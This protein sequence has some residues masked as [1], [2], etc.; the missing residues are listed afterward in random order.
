MKAIAATLLLACCSCCAL[1]QDK[2]AVAAAE[3]ACGPQDSQFSVTSDESR[4][5]TPTPESGKALIYV[6]QGAPR[7]TRVGADGKWLGALKRGTYFSV[8]VDPGEHH[9]CARVDILLAHYVSFHELNARAGETYY[10]VAHY[11]ASDGEFT[12]NQ[13][14]SDQGKYLVAL[15]KFGASRPK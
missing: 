9:L 6:V 4:H 13:V 11:A 7:S 10:F 5:P 12:L 8:S 3:A 15:A 1:G 14:D 2:V